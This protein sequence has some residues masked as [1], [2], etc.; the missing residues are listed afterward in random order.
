MS[1]KRPRLFIFVDYYK[2]GFAGGGPRV[3]IENIVLNFSAQYR[4]YI[5]T[6]AYEYGRTKSYQGLL[7]RWKRLDRAAVY[8]SPKTLNRL[9]YYIIIILRLR[10]TFIW[11]NS[12]FSPVSTIPILLLRSFLSLFSKV[13]RIAI[14]PRGEFYS[15]ALTSSFHK[16]RVWLYIFQ[17]FVY[18]R[19]LVWAVSNTQEY[20]SLLHVFGCHSQDFISKQSGN[21]LFFSQ[22]DPDP[23]IYVVPNISRLTSI[24]PGINKGYKV[25]LV[26]ANNRTTKLVFLSRICP[27][28]N[29]LFAIRALEDV[30]SSVEFYVYGPIEDRSYWDE[31][32]QTASSLPS[33]I[34][35]IYMGPLSPN[36]VVSTLTNY[37]LFVFPTLGENYGHVIVEAL[38]A[39]LPILISNNTPWSHKPCPGFCSLSLDSHLS[40]AN[41]IDQYCEDRL[42]K[43]LEARISASLVFKEFMLS[44]DSVLKTKNFLSEL[45]K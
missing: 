5:I 40:W 45:S 16:K 25:D 17:H 41:Y 15:G 4:I 27:K 33:S 26:R 37:D 36:D 29:L 12:F 35:F 8:Y 42:A 13:S 38:S 34:K 28:K 6:Q 1:F 9:L 19:D 43:P 22:E 7:N 21:N 3:S 14:S 11:L 31:C 44:S 10:P 23:S 39:S 32:V 30:R 18:K 2:P 24:P 20:S